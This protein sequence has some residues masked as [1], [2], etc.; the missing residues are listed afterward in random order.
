MKNLRVK[1]AENCVGR[2]WRFGIYE[3]RKQLMLNAPHHSGNETWSYWYQKAAAIRNAKKMAIRIGIPY[4]D[5]II[6]QHG[7]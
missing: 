4:S 7:C 6:K 2:S 1:V 5:E 3:G